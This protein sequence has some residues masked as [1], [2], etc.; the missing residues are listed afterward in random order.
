MTVNDLSNSLALYKAFPF[1]SQVVVVYIFIHSP[2]KAEAG[3]TL[4]AQ[5]QPGLQSRANSRTFKFT[6]RNPVSKII[7][8]PFAQNF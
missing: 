3:G 6:Q 8:F 1:L 5:G 2:W 7:F 4:G